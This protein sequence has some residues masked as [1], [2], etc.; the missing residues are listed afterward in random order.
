M[1][2]FGSISVSERLGDNS[3]LSKLSKILDWSLL[4]DK[5][6]TLDNRVNNASKGGRPPYD[7][8]SMFKLLLLGQWHSLSDPE[9]EYALRIRLDFLS[10]CDFDITD[11]VPDETTICRYRNKL[12]DL[13]ILEEL[14]SDINS[15]LERQNLKVRKAEM[16][17]VDATIIESAARPKN[18]VLDEIS[19][20]RQESLLSSPSDNVDNNNSS[21]NSTHEETILTSDKDA[22]W[23]K[24]GKKC[25]FGYKSFAATDEE[26]YV[27]QTHTTP[28]NESEVNKLE[29][30][31]S[32]GINAKRLSGDKAYDSKHNRSL[33]KAK[34]IKSA[35]MY[36]AKKNKPLTHWQKKYNKLVSKKRFR[37]EQSFGTL[38]RLFNFSRA[39]YFNQQKAH[40][41]FVLKSICL[42]LLKAI[43]KVKLIPPKLLTRVSY[44]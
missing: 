33:L 43:N 41:Q 30:I 14:L 39:S 16:A 18:P 23:L 1:R 35:I 5:L 10:F 4:K 32:K 22:K 20:D 28:A 25:Y 21:S 38:K 27:V 13:G 37:V 7:N 34:K 29:V 12:I 3:K 44:V 36:K 42:N 11:N 26:G 6:S 17:I 19:Q 8:L 40:A 9:L 15:Q 31:L 24:K 2:S